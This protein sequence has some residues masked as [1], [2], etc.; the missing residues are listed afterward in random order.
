[1][2][3]SPRRATQVDEAGAVTPGPHHATPPCRHFPECGGCQLQHVDDEAYRA[4]LVDRVAGALAAQGVAMPEIRSPHLSPPR[5]RRRA[6]LK[7]AGGSI[8]FNAAGQPPH[9]RHAR[10]PYPSA[11]VVRSGRAA[12]PAAHPARGGHA[13]AGRSGRRSAAERRRRRRSRRGRGARGFR[14]GASAGAA[15]RRR[16]P[17]PADPVGAGAGD[18][19]ARRRAGRPAARRLPAGD[20]GRRGGA[21][22]RGARG[23]RRC[24]DGRRSFRRPRHLRAGPRCAGLCGRSGSRDAALALKAAAGAAGRPV[25]VEHRDLYRRPL[26]PAEL[27]RFDAVVLDP[28]RAGARGAGRARSP[29]RACRASPMSPAIPRPSPAMR[30]GWRRAA[31]GSIGCVRSASSAGRSMSSSPPA[32]PASSLRAPAYRR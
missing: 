9:R 4:Y 21:G 10:M 15:R 17:W 13:D 29:P 14:R 18:R 32:S 26:E 25:F 23:G 12:S 3:R 1:M 27:D 28:P 8:G 22:R 2:S 31:I 19:H 7:A 16:R 24:G 5:S 6:T 20:G 30:S 11:G